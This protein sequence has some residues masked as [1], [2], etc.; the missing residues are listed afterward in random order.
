MFSSDVEMGGV[1]L[2][3]IHSRILEDGRIE[4]SFVDATGEMITPDLRYLAADIP[5]GVWLRS[6]EISA[7]PENPEE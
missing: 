7:T 6:G 5:V 4:L 2:G 1:V 3:R